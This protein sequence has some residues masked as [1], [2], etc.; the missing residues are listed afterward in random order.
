M[1]CHGTGDGSRAQG[2]G[3]ENEPLPGAWVVPGVCGKVHLLV[4]SQ[5][6]P[7]LSPFCEHLVA[8]LGT[9]PIYKGFCA[10]GSGA[11]YLENYLYEEIN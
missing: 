3:Q 1:S 2:A 7:G 6:W 10:L 5:P 9:A 4:I 11:H 8:G